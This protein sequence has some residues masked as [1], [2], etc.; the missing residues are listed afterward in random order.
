[1]A[2]ALCDQQQRLVFEGSPPWISQSQFAQGFT[3]AKA[4]DNTASASAL[5]WSDRI[6]AAPTHS[7]CDQRGQSLPGQEHN[8]EP[9]R[10]QFGFWQALLIIR[11][12]I[13]IFV[14]RLQRRPRSSI[15]RGTE[16]KGLSFWRT[17]PLRCAVGLSA[18]G[19]VSHNRTVEGTR[20]DREWLAH[21]S[22]WTSFNLFT[23]SLLG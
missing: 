14:A 3:A 15:G 12:E 2:G 9:S 10:Q 21:D 19:F 18:R 17:K 11:H 1:M 6:A 4:P 20:L 23:P 7:T 13:S 8:A 16:F 22:G 5:T